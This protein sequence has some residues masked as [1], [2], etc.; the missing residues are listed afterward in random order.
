MMRHTNTSLDNSQQQLLKAFMNSIRDKTYSAAETVN[1]AWKLIQNETNIDINTLIA[2]Q[3]DENDPFTYYCNP[4]HVA[5][6]VNNLAAVIALLKLN[7]DPNC[8]DSKETRGRYVPLRIALDKKYFE[9]ASKLIEHGAYSDSRSIYGSKQKQTVVKRDNEVKDSKIFWTKTY[10]KSITDNEEHLHPTL[11]R[12]Y[13][14]SNKN[15]Q[16]IFLINNGANLNPQIPH[17]SLKAMMSGTKTW[18]DVDEEFLKTYATEHCP[19]LILEAYEKHMYDVVEAILKRDRK[20]VDDKYPSQHQFASNAM[21][22]IAAI[23]NNLKMIEMLLY[24]GA[25]PIEENNKPEIPLILVANRKKFDEDTLQIARLLIL[26]TASQNPDVN[27]ELKVINPPNKNLISIIN[28][29]LYITACLQSVFKYATHIDGKLNAYNTNK[30]IIQQAFINSKIGWFGN[31]VAINNKQECDEMKG[32][33]VAC[34]IV[35]KEILQKINDIYRILIGTQNDDPFLFTELIKDF[36][37]KKDGNSVGYQ[38]L[39]HK[40]QNWYPRLRY[41]YLYPGL[42][43]SQKV[44]QQSEISEDASDSSRAKINLQLPPIFDQETHVILP[45]NGKGYTADLLQPGSSEPSLKSPS[46]PLPPRN[47]TPTSIEGEQQLK[48]SMESVPP[49]TDSEVSTSPESLQPTTPVPPPPPPPSSHTTSTSTIQNLLE[50]IRARQDNPMEGLTHVGTEASQ[51]ADN[52]KRKSEDLLQSAIEAA[53]G[54]RR[55]S[56]E[57]K[58]QEDDWSDNEDKE[59]PPSPGPSP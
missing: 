50:Q 12:Y 44:D 29:M 21:L 2:F 52:S 57:P 41:P 45:E 53:V 26:K 22:H 17:D 40:I 1:R 35:F 13:V 10:G 32:A 23:E 15:E 51:K 39:V 18:Q 30:G 19:S 33:R 3:V 43:D 55:V 31:V 47:L 38:F 11:L 20:Y 49:S 16:A 9:I 46:P 56:L 54:K 48:E 5:V 36:L 42:V 14:E 4:L 8:A 58:K 25:N 7:A 28:N 24:F 6:S 37:S 27:E 59:N 34:A